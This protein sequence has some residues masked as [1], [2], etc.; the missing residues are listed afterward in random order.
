M[1]KFFKPKEINKETSETDL[2]QDTSKD[3]IKSIKE[4]KTEDKELSDL[5]FHVSMGAAEVGKTYPLFGY[6]SEIISEGGENNQVIVRLNND[7]IILKMKY[8]GDSLEVMKDRVFE[9]GIFVSTVTE[10]TKDNGIVADCQT[11]IYGRKQQMG[12]A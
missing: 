4:T 8:V 9:T 12:S 2:T 7:K 10:I 11:V 1:S 3:L 6:V 5:G